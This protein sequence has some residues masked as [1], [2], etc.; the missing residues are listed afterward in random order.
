MYVYRQ[1]ETYPDLFTVGFYMPDGK[2]EPESD[3]AQACDAAARVHYLNG[4]TD[5]ELIEKLEKRLANLET[6]A[7]RQAGAPAW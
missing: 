4:S 5:A 3:H 2:W 7:G 1:T 6:W